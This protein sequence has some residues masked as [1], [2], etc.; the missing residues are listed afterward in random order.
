M[1]W[2]HL[3]KKR[4]SCQKRPFSPGG[5]NDQ[6]KV[7]LKEVCASFLEPRSLPQGFSEHFGILM[8]ECHI[9]PKICHIYFGHPITIKCLYKSE[10]RKRVAD[11]FPNTSRQSTATY[12][13]LANLFFANASVLHFLFFPTFPFSYQAGSQYS[14]L[15]LFYIIC[16]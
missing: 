16:F 4:P 8:P 13:Q 7:W 5:V 1:K 10:R 9:W 15:L 6:L 11:R 3:L 14:L 2:T 12:K